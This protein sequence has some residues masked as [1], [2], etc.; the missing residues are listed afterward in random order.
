MRV[1]CGGWSSVGALGDL[2]PRGRLWLIGV[3]GG[4]RGAP[5]RGGPPGVEGEASRR[6]GCCGGTAV[7]L[8]ASGGETPCRAL[9][10]DSHLVFGD[11][12]RGPP[13]PRWRPAAAP[14]ATVPLW[15]LSRCRP[16]P[17]SPSS[18]PLVCLTSRLS[19]PHL[20]TP[21]PA[22]WCVSLSWARCGPAPCPP[23]L[24]CP[25]CPPVS[26]RV[27]EGWPSATPPPPRRVP[28]PPG[29]AELT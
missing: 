12:P 28:L 1:G 29:S 5:A 3:V 25:A 26:L 22:S 9:A 20:P 8:E 2:F 7:V 16:L 17:R 15:H 10:A 4:G 18:L 24:P 23:P 13:P 11:G 6:P 27:V 14:S 21:G 19:G